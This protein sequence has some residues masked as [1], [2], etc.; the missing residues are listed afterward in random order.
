MPLCVT[1]EEVK[2]LAKHASDPIVKAI[3]A[4]LL[5]TR[6]QLAKIARLKR[7]EDIRVN[8]FMASLQAA[9]EPNYRI[10]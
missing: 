6:K 2:S 10:F 3:A 1:N 5:R 7:E 9:D 4:E 8:E